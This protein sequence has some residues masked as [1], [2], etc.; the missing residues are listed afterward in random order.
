MGDIV[1]PRRKTTEEFV[2][3]AIAIHGTKYGYENVDY[4]QNK[5]KVLITC[6][7]HGDFEQTPNS[8]LNGRGC[9]R[10]TK[11][12]LGLEEFIQKAT[13]IHKGLY[14]YSMATYL[15]AG[16][17]ITAICNEHGMFEKIACEHLQG[18]GCPKC[19][20][21][22][23]YKN[24]IN[25]SAKSFESRAKE[26]H[27]ELYDYS[28]SVYAGA[29]SPI[30]IRCKIHGEFTTTPSTHLSGSI[31]KQCYLDARRGTTE[32]FI[33]NAHCVHE[34]LYDYTNVVYG[35]NNTQPVE[36]LCSSHGSFSQTPNDHLGG[37]GCPT[38]GDI[39]KLISPYNSAK[40]YT[41]YYFKIE[42][43]YKIG[44]TGNSLHARYPK[45]DLDRMSEIRTWKGLS[46]ADA[47]KRE[48]AIVENYKKYKYTGITP[49]LSDTG[50]TECFT[51]D[52]YK[53][54]LQ[55]GCNGIN[56]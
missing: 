24:K 10:C 25:S 27:K 41:L 1:M 46:G 17:K 15:G 42:N 44:I 3:D 38:C 14:T 22:K 13:K 8:H 39:S 28:S 30:I 34:E 19:A 12:M 55:E 37:A 49:F 21:A 43:I 11:N 47:V 2:V 35:T 23:G 26:V 53:I 33:A 52:V 54:S 50:T 36:I 6:S 51:E 5:K 31:C 9:T 20:K 45:R 4:V 40:Q 16:E 7:L 32:K 29:T 56:S 48:Q 18:K